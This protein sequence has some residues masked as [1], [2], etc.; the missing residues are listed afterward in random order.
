MGG[1]AHPR[2][3]AVCPTDVDATCSMSSLWRHH[4][5]ECQTENVSCQ[6]RD[7]YFKCGYT[8]FGSCPRMQSTTGIRQITPG[9]RRYSLQT[10]RSC[11]GRNRKTQSYDKKDGG[12]SRYLN[13]Q[14]HLNQVQP[15]RDTIIE[16]SP[17]P[18]SGRSACSALSAQR[19]PVTMSLPNCK[20]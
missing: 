5:V 7:D 20:C 10:M 9:S 17:S 14:R 1:N 11:I 15:T 2:A 18:T 12:K 8:Y 3:S 13:L 6:R 16:N 19:S 4:E